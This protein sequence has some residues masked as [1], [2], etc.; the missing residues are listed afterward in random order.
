MTA[1]EGRQLESTAVV[2]SVESLA[3]ERGLTPAE[4]VILEH[5]LS[6]LT[7]Q[8][9]AGRQEVALPT[10][11]THIARLHEKFGVKRTLDLVRLAMSRG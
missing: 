2:Q 9:I 7:P 1:D 11:R 10:I 4:T 8:E 3:A 6:G 5:L